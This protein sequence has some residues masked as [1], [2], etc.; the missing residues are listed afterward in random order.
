M[1]PAHS[2][3]KSTNLEIDMRT[4]ANGLWILFLLMFTGCAFE[5]TDG[6]DPSFARG[7]HG[8]APPADNVEPDADQPDIDAGV[9]SA[10]NVEPDAD[11][12]DIDAGVESSC[13]PFAPSNLP[14]DIACEATEEL[15]ISAENCGGNVELCIHTDLGIIS[16]TC[17]P[18]SIGGCVDMDYGFQVIEQSDLSEIGVFTAR[19]IRIDPTMRI[20]VV[21]QRPLV[22]VASDSIEVLGA[23]TATP[24]STRHQGNAGGFTTPDNADEGPGAG[25]GGGH[26]G[27]NGMGAGGGSYCGPGGNGGLAL[28]PDGMG[29]AVNGTAEVIPLRGGSSGGSTWITTG[30][31][32]GGAVQLVAGEVINITDLGSIHV[33]GAGGHQHGAGAGSGGAILL[34]SQVVL[35]AGAL[36]ANGGGGAG[37]NYGSTAGEMARASTVRAAGG[38]GGDRTATV[39][40]IGGSGSAGTVLDGNAGGIGE[41]EKG[42]GGGGGAGWI[43]I[44]T[45]SGDADIDGALSPEAGDCAT[46]G[47]VAQQDS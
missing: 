29:G 38:E 6:G 12:P 14:E 47:R 15:V 39:G 31:S 8:D 23:I 7:P 3:S 26:R 5:L 35:M 33:G 34:E 20:R 37:G 44:N 43:R 11:Q 17:S 21:G 46:Q 4:C 45:T 19:S 22:L 36:A 27:S 9:E 13:L 40:G 18:Y 16:A 25:P 41:G 24:R 10:D 2:N 30:G 28:D 1:G 32:G 42:G